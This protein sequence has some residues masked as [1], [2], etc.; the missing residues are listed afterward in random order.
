[1]SFLIKF[2]EPLT[3]KRFNLREY[4]TF[5]D[6]TSSFFKPRLINVHVHCISRTVVAYQNPF[7]GDYCVHKSRAGPKGYVN[8]LQQPD[9]PDS[10]L[11]D[12]YEPLNLEPL[13]PRPDLPHVI[14][15]KMPPEIVS[16]PQVRELFLQTP[17]LL[18]FS[19]KSLQLI[20]LKSFFVWLNIW[21]CRT[22]LNFS[23]L[24]LIGGRCD[25]TGWIGETSNS[26]R[27]YSTKILCHSF[28]LDD[29]VLFIT[30]TFNI[31][32]VYVIAQLLRI[33][34]KSKEI[35]H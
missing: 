26:R 28:W 17:L 1:M 14:Q 32:S 3:L 33:G 18:Y 29:S 15:D 9:S 27:W 20:T 34:V 21:N 6:I 2:N 19:R 4:L 25:A 11:S 10:G 16:M 31:K 22:G 13:G 24:D 30:A 12:E 23:F 5:P 7:T 35:V 8:N